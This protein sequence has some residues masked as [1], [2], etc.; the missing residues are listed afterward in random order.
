MS[1]WKFMRRGAVM[2][3][4]LALLS[5]ARVRPLRKRRCDLFS[6]RFVAPMAIR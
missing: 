2:A 6:Y 3:T 1:G 4:V 5:P